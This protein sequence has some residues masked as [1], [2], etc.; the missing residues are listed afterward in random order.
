MKHQRHKAILDLV[1]SGE[2]ASQDDLMRGLKARHIDVSQ[3]TLSRDIQELRLAKAGG[4]YVVV[5]SESSARPATEDSWRRILRE[6]LIDVAVAQ[7]I[8]VVKTGAGHAST[9]S[10][11][12]DETGWPEAIGTIAGE[13]TVFIA[14][15][16]EKDGKKLEH[17]IR[18]LL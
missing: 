1:Q 9:V 7:N 10:Q 16:S 6:F 2:I 13:N 14:V 3:A 4:V 8:V 17:R 11:A 5:D 18:E 12:L 15:R